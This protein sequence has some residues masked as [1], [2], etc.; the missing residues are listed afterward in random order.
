MKVL[1]TGADGMLG[2]RVC[3]ALSRKHEVIPTDIHLPLDIC[4]W[5]ADLLSSHLILDICDS[6]AVFEC[7]RKQQPDIIIHCAAMTD[8]DACTRNPDDAF[9]INAIG[10]SNL[11][12]AGAEIGASL[13]YIS[14]DYV[15]DGTGSR[16]YTEFDSP[17]PINEYGASKLAGENAVKELLKKFYIIRTSWLFAPTHKNFPL[18]I[19]RAA[20]AGNELKIVSDQFGSP[21]YADDMAGFTASL[22]D[23]G[24]FGTYHFTNA[25]NCSWYEFARKILDLAGMSHVNITPIESA[26]WPTP[27]VRPKYSVLRHYRLELTGRDVSRTWEEAAAEFI[28]EW[29]TVK[30]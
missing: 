6:D 12:C 29:T 22:V 10:T 11:A 14:T 27:T 30:Q 20:Q 1:V 16:P 19:L 2:S 17:N 4:D 24:C 21:T 23:T 9:R 26:Q 25:G 8:V 5:N 28:K 13:A 18:S 3:K 15:F 7:L